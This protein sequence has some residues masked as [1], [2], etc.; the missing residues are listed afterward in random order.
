DDVELRGGREIVAHQHVVERFGI[1]FE[2]VVIAFVGRKQVLQVGEHGGAARRVGRR[3]INRIA[4][5]DIVVADRS[6]PLEHVERLLELELVEVAGDDN[7]GVRIGAQHA[8]D[9]IVDRLRLRGAGHLT[10]VEWR[11]VA[12]QQGGAAAFRGEVIV[13]DDDL[14]AIEVEGG[15]QRRA[16]LE[17]RIVRGG[18]FIAVGGGVGRRAS[19]GGGRRGVGRPRV[20]RSRFRRYYVVAVE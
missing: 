11:L 10:G 13:D 14:L 17:E 3:R 19:L 8:V 12:T 4:A 5:G 9:E 15:D 16:R 2:Y 18:G 1:A 7:L 6:R 20:S